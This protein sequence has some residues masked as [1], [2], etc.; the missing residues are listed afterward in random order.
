MNEEENANKLYNHN[1]ITK[2]AF[3]FSSSVI[4]VVVVVE[5]FK[6]PTHAFSRLLMICSEFSKDML[7]NYYW[8]FLYIYR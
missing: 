3:D 4:F 2:I 5:A 7:Y 1:L 8:A 6:K